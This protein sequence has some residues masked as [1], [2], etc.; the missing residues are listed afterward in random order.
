MCFIFIHKLNRKLN[1]L[2]ILKSLN[3]CTKQIHY[4][5]H[6]NLWIFILN[7]HYIHIR[8]ISWF[9]CF[10]CFLNCNIICKSDYDSLYGIWLWKIFYETIPQK[11]QY[12]YIYVPINSYNLMCIRYIIEIMLN[13]ISIYILIY[14]NITRLHI[15]TYKFRFCFQFWDI[16]SRA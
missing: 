8:F 15:N 2:L 10:Q 1:P 4:M 3:Q 6:L 16:K 14:E 9:L 11:L 13:D 12:I 7:K 5:L